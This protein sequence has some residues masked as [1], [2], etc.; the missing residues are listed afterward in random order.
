MSLT[1]GSLCSGYGGLDL[2][3]EEFFDAETRWFAEYEEAP[4]KVLS[5]HWPEVPNLGDMTKIDWASVEPVDIVH[6]GTPCQDLSTAGKR[7]GMVEGTRS[8]LW[9]QMR[10]AIATIRPSYV[11][12]ENVRGAFTTY[13]S[14]EVESEPGLLGI[15][16]RQNPGLR[17]LGRVLGDLSQ[18]GYDCRW[19]SVEAAEVGAPHHRLRVFVLATDTQSGSWRIVERDGCNAS[20]A[21]FATRGERGVPASG[22][23]KGRRSRPDAGRRGRASTAVSGRAPFRGLSRGSSAEKARKGHGDG[24]GD[25]RRERTDPDQRKTPS[26]A[27][28]RGRRGRTFEPFG[29]PLRR[30]S[31]SRRGETAWGAYE[32]AIRRWESA[33]GRRAPAP[34]ELSGRGSQRLSPA[35]VEWMMGLPKGWITD[36]ALGLSRTEQLKALGNGVVPQQAYRAFEIMAGFDHLAVAA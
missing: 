11:I 10:E 9:V 26:D 3:V 35:F 4:S 5:A 1:A 13:A 24:L 33:L 22:E 14:S 30:A 32:P 12:W 18:L 31:S 20:H 28:S 15:Y 25:P 29:Q 8:N 2:A 19:V 23:T 16:G 36:S 7:T 27:A 21:D 34:T 17:A 6:G